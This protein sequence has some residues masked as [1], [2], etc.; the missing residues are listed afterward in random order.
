MRANKAKVNI[1]I[2]GGRPKAIAKRASLSKSMDIVAAAKKNATNVKV[3]QNVGKAKAQ[4]NATV[5][6]VTDPVNFY[7]LK[8]SW[9]LNSCC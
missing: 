7:E 2:E 3:A 6:Q 5:N 1:K 8:L 4:R 9:L